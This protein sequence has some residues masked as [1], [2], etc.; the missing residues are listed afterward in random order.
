VRKTGRAIVASQACRTGSYT[1]EIASQIQEL[2]FDYLDAPVGRIGALD[3]VSPQ[4]YV[5][6]QVYLPN[7][8]TIVEMARKLVGK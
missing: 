4:S 1:G 2:A 6:E 7:A 8:G 5:L 3:G